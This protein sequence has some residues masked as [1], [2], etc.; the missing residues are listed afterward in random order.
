MSGCLWGTSGDHKPCG[1]HNYACALE[2]FRTS[3]ANQKNSLDL[4]LGAN[5][6]L[7]TEL[8]AQACL[9]LPTSPSVRPHL[10]TV[11]LAQIRQL[12]T[13]GGL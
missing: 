8:R 5:L 11:R 9:S 3:S 10:V 4:G 6:D 7:C 2:A 13:R 1:V 12:R